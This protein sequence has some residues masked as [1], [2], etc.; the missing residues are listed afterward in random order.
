MTP[1]IEQF[2]SHNRPAS[3]CLVVDLD[4]IEQ[5]HQ[6]IANGLPEA[7]LFYAVKANPAAPI[8]DRLVGL[9]AN[10][11]AA[12]LNEIEACLQAGAKPDH[13]SFGN[14]LK[15]AAD[16]AS[17]HRLGVDLFAFDSEGELDKLAAHAPGARVYCRILTENGNAEWPLSRKFG[18]EYEMAIDLMVMAQQRGL[19]P[20]GVSFHVGSQ[21]IDPHQWDGAI[22]RAARVFRGVSGKGINLE[23]LNLGGGFPARYREDILGFNN[24]STAIRASLVRHFGANVP[25]LMIEPGRAIAASAGVLQ[26]EVVLVSKKRADAERRWVYLDVGLFGGLAETLG[27]AIKYDIKTSRD[28]GATGPVAIAG[29]TCDSADILYEHTVYQLPLDLT[30]GDGVLIETAGAYTTTYASVGFNGFEPLREH[31]I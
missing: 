27:E 14:T 15:K 28:G 4:V 25:N 7:A 31:H 30:S 20:Y 29:P 19:V 6:L 11:D 8:L 13:V 17:A 5:N 21:Q 3:P 10:F 12:S 24:F 26:A 1:K 2:L 18:C 23:M 16:I 9:G 22:E